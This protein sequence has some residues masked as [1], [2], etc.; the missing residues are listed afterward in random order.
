MYRVG[1][2][3]KHTERGDIYLLANVGE[4]VT[5]VGIKK[6]NRWADKARLHEFENMFQVNAKEWNV[7]TNYKPHKFIPI[8]VKII[9]APDW[10]V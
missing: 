8:N 10:E 3:F 6:G 7:V 5:L 4:F 2:Y 1:Q 9:P